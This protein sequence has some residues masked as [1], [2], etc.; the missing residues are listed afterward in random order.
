M[1]VSKIDDTVRVDGDAVR[2]ASS[3]FPG[4]TVH[5]GHETL[6]A[7]DVAPFPRWR[8]RACG[9]EL[10][11]AIFAV[12]GESTTVVRWRHL[13]GP[14][15]DIDVRPFYAMRFFHHVRR[16]SSARDF[17]VVDAPHRLTVKIGDLPP[18]ALAHDGQFDPLSDMWRDFELGEE[19]R[20]G[21]EDR[22]DLFTPGVLRLHLEPSSEVA[23]IFSLRPHAASEAA[24]LETAEVARRGELVSAHRGFDARLGELALA[25][26]TYLARIGER[27]TIVAGFPWFEDW[28]RD[29]MLSLP[30]LLIATGRLDDAFQML[31]AWADEVVAGIVPNRFPDGTARPELNSVDSALLFVEAVRL[32]AASGVDRRRLQ[33]RLYPRVLEIVTAYA[34][35]TI[36]GIG[37]DDDGLLRAASPHHALTWMDA[38]I[39]GVA[40]TPRRGKPVEI[41]ALWHSAN[42]TAAELAHAFGNPVLA[43]ELRSLARRTQTAFVRRFWDEERGFCADVVDPTDEPWPEASYGPGTVDPRL[44]PNQLFALSLGRDLLSRAQS[45]SVLDAVTR[46]LLTPRGLRTLAPGEPGY[47]GRF[48]GDPRSRDSAYHQGTVWPWLFGIYAR[49]IVATRGYNA[50]TREEV[51]AVLDPFVRDARREQCVGQIAEVYDGDAP[52]RAG[53]CPAQAWSVAEVLRC[54]MEIVEGIGKERISIPPSLEVEPRFTSAELVDFAS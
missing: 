17:E 18:V 29:T 54:W 39:D 36:H 14:A 2:L 40:V 26:S 9:I 13:G 46:H 44:R 48:E 21:L 50:Q 31:E 49:A 10:E 3:F 22:E 51:F 5:P 4:G 35:G 27:D 42:L 11:R 24:V 30:G 6:T 12:H 15:C 20:R 52:H 33:V 25:G 7:F 37:C 34:R 38:V 23:I 16:G 43:A 32:L 45:E 28:G 41:Q 47:R 53:G 1:L 19:A 8:M